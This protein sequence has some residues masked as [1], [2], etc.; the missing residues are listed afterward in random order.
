MV[1]DAEADLLDGEKVAVTLAQL[2]DEEQVVI[3]GVVARQDVA[4]LDRRVAVR[5]DF[6]ALARRFLVVYE[7]DFISIALYYRSKHN[8]TLAT[9]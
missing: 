8:R 6:R 2:V 1:L 7:G 5:L 9:S 4:L 3:G